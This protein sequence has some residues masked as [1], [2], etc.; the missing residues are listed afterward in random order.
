MIELYCGQNGGVWD[1]AHFVVKKNE[2][3][4]EKKILFLT[5]SPFII[6]L[7]ELFNDENDLILGERK[8]NILNLF[9][10]Y[11][12]VAY[13]HFNHEDGPDSGSLELAL[14]CRQGLL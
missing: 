5:S 11:H 13:E 3:T 7:H 4:L 1:N 12:P 2:K 10:I 8:N 14:L 9:P 6:L